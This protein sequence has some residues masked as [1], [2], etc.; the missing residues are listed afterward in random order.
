MTNNSWYD[1]LL[2][3]TKENLCWK[4]QSIFILSDWE[5]QQISD[6]IQSTNDID[7]LH[8]Y[9]YRINTILQKSWAVAVKL[10]ENAWEED[11]EELKSIMEK[12]IIN[13]LNKEQEQLSEQMWDIQNH[14]NI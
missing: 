12:D 1:V 8:Y 5:K 14:I 6:A 4:V 7:Q 9:E 3:K 2:D 10:I 13:K 11:L